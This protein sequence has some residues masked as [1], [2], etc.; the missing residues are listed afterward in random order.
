MKITQDVREFAR[1]MG[2]SEKQALESGMEEMKKEFRRRGGK[3]YQ[4]V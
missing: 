4:R 2:I 3:I 1:R